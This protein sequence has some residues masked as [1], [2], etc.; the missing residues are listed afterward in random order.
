MERSY[1]NALVVL[2]CLHYDVLPSYHTC[3]G[4]GLCY[5]CAF[6]VQTS[7][8]LKNQLQKSICKGRQFEGC[9]GHLSPMYAPGAL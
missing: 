3:V 9:V 4:S 7:A 2:D 1:G 5:T 8:A 6:R